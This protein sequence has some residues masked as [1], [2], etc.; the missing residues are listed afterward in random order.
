MQIAI[1]CTKCERYAWMSSQE[2]L[3]HW[4]YVCRLCQTQT[5][6]KQNV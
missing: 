2:R 6:Q 4:P 1:P 3:D 5:E